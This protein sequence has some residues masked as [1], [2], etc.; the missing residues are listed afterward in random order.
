MK[1]LNEQFQDH[2]NYI[3]S[4]IPTLVRMTKEKNN[5]IKPESRFERAR[6]YVERLQQNFDAKFVFKPSKKT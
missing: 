4:I 6:M 3:K 1:K 5:Q 2:N